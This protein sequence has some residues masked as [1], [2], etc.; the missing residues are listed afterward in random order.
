MGMSQPT[1][2]PFRPRM[3][4]VRLRWYTCSKEG[5]NARG[6][7]TREIAM[8]AYWVSCAASLCKNATH[9]RHIR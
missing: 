7:N 8:G 1:F 6:Q 2:D 4:R 5:C 3:L 9:S